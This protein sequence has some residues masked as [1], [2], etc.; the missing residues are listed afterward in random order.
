MDG[1]NVSRGAGTVAGAATALDPFEDLF[2]MDRDGL[3]RVDPDA[4]L[5]SLHPKNRDGHV[6]A[7][8]N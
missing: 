8:D 2:A 6:L 3:G 4:N 7:D 5:V 1:L